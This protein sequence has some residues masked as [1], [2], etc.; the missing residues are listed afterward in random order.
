MWYLPALALSALVL[1]GCD[2]DGD[3]G[4]NVEQ[5]PA[6]AFVARYVPTGG[7]R[8]FMPYPNDI[9]GT[10]NQPDGTINVPGTLSTYGA[11]GAL[12]PSVNLI[13]GFSTTAPVWV[14]FTAP[15]DITSV[16]PYLPTPPTGA[17]ALPGTN[18]WVVDITDLLAGGAPIPLIP[19]IPGQTDAIADYAYQLSSA[20][21]SD[22]A[23]LEIV[24]VKPFGPD[25]TIAFLVTAGVADT[26]G[27]ALQPDNQFREIRDACFSGETLANGIL[28]SIKTNA[29]CPIL[30]AAAGLFG[31][32]PDAFMVA[33]TAST[34]SVGDSLAVIDETATS[35]TSVLVPT[36]FNTN[37]IIPALPGLA[38][39]Y[40]GTIEVPYYMDLTNP[41]GS[42]WLGAGGS[43][44]TRDNPEPV[45]T[46]TLTIPF[47]A[48]VPNVNS[49]QEE[50]PEG[51][52]VVIY[53]HGVTTDRTTLIPIADTLAS[54]GFVA[55]AIDLPLHGIRDPANPLYQGPEN[56]A[57]PFGNNERHFFLDNFQQNGAPGPDGMIDNGAQLFSISLTSPL[58]T[59]DYGR[60][61]SS[62]L[63]NLVRTIPTINLDQDPDP[64]LDSTRI[65]FVAISL[66]S[67]LGSSF[68]G[69]T[70]E[71]ATA[72]LSSPGGNWTGF[73]TDPNSF[74]GRGL[75]AALSAATGM[76]PNTLD[77]DT[78]L[79]DWQHALDAV[80][81]LNYAAIIAANS[82]VHVIEI[83]NDN[84]VPNSV[85]ENF[86]RVA[87]LDSISETTVD[88]DGIR[89]IV[90]F[91]DGGHGSLLDPNSVIVDLDTGEVIQGPN[92]L[93]TFEMQVEAAAFA[94]SF[95]TQLPINT[96]LP[97][98][99]GATCDCVLAP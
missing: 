26:S 35:Q 53:Q 77:F 66:G 93:V 14:P 70:T 58:T 9:W 42:T 63:I 88:P 19:L 52:P 2:T 61:G 78:Y 90:R 87:G 17:P 65:H 32:P 71:V 37:N 68:L 24:P 85:T 92:P 15:I 12:L 47:I 46:T 10:A 89:G 25:R 54:Q 75:V 80:E 98:A 57:N 72:T 73:L 81:P 23:V 5:K 95:G 28:E 22:G 11:A 1:G 30:Q 91:T 94:L 7:N 45:P 48:T 41:Y 74:F 27:N 49:G 43:T 56:E 51:W 64:D 59:R 38:D 60:Q 83:L 29:V 34:M 33:W 8:N 6:P 44:L 13:D 20:T 55:V 21:D 50:P 69:N 67:L 82:P 96:P 3:T 16:V 84:T 4:V 97:Q 36:G 86:A 39:I 62:D 40:T 18:L 79:R 76:Q 31:A 99:G